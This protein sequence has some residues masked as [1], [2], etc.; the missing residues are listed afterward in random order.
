V[1]VLA[2]VGDGPRRYAVAL[3]VRDAHGH[4]VMT[5]ISD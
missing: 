2:R 3:E 1:R 4:R 5:E